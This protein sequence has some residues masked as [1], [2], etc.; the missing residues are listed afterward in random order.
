[1]IMNHPVGIM[2]TSHVSLASWCDILLG[3]TE[4]TLTP[5]IYV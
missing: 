4:M 2:N 5:V 1:M 3:T